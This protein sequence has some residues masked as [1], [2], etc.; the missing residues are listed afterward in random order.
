MHLKSPLELAVDFCAWRLLFII[1]C[2]SHQLYVYMGGYNQ[3]NLLAVIMCYYE[4]IFYR[5][6]RQD[7]VVVVGNTFI[8]G[9]SP[10]MKVL[11]IETW[12]W[13]ARYRFGEMAYNIGLVF[14]ARDITPKHGVIAYAAINRSK[15]IPHTECL[16]LGWSRTSVVSAL[17]IVSTILEHVYR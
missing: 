7:L 11:A 3:L 10:T 2:L 17:I 15:L 6:R 12:R 13:H 5:Q 9:V 8:R 1:V 4:I 16:F 14:T